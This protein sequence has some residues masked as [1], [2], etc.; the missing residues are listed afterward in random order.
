MQ[1]IQEFFSEEELFWVKPQNRCVYVGGGGAGEV[2]FFIEKVSLASKM[3]N[4]QSGPAG[5]G[6]VA[7]TAFPVVLP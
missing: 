5:P 2:S 3:R 7:P 6:T 1:N 4:W